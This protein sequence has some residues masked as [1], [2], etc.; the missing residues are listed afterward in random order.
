MIHHVSK[1]TP[2]I[3]TVVD[4]GAVVC[5]LGK[6]LAVRGPK[7]DLIGYNVG[8]NAANPIYWQ[9][10]GE[11]GMW[12]WSNSGSIF[13][14]GALEIDS[15]DLPVTILRREAISLNVK[16]YMLGGILALGCG[17]PLENNPTPYIKPCCFANVDGT[18]ANLCA[19]SRP[20]FRPIKSVGPTGPNSISYYEVWQSIIPAFAAVWHPGYDVTIGV[21]CQVA[22]LSLYAGND[23]LGC[24]PSEHAAQEVTIFIT[25]S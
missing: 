20:H 4:G 9:A 13:N 24:L 5:T 25:E 7:A 18:G 15:C 14:G 21:Y 23:W 8:P 2:N 17:F 19:A 10:N 11:P 12:R 6:E 3:L 16:P 22:A 1:T